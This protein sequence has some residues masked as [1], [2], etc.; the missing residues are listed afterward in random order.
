MARL[1]FFF[2]LSYLGFEV[3]RSRAKAKP[4]NKVISIDPVIIR[5]TVPGGRVATPLSISFS[6]ALSSLEKWAVSAEQV[7][8]AVLVHSRD[9]VPSTDPPAVVVTDVPTGYDITIDYPDVSDR[10]SVDTLEQRIESIDERL[11]GRISNIVF[12]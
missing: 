7:K 4:Q 11:K 5:G 8:D 6:L 10:P 2:I 3:L 1:F 9:V 12:V